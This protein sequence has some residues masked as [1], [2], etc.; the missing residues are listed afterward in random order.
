MKNIRKFTACVKGIQL[1][2]MGIGKPARR[3][4]VALL[5]TCM[6][7]FPSC[8]YLDVVPDN[9]ATIDNAFNLRLQAQKYLLTC[10]S[11]LPNLG[12]M[13]SNPALV[14]GDE[15]WFFY[16]YV[17]NDP[18][19]PIPTT[20]E[21]ARGNQN[22][23][24]PMLN[25]WDGTNGGKPLFQGIR[26]CNTFLE[27]IGRVPDMES[28]EKN[29]WIAEVKFLK[30]YYHWFL[31]R[32]YGP[33]PIVDKNLPVSSSPDEVKVYRNPVDSC[34]NYIVDLIDSAALD[35][36]AV[37]DFPVSEMGRI[38]KPIAL[39]IKA[40]ILMNYASPLFNGNSDYANFVDNKG[41]QL[42]NPAYDPSKWQRAAQACKEAIDLCESL[43]YQL[44]HF[45]PPVGSS[46]VSIGPEIQTQMDIRN[47]V[48]EKWNSEMIWG[49]SNSM[50]TTIQQ[51]GL[52]N[53]DPL[54]GNQ[55]T[56]PE[57]E[58]APP[59][60][61][62]RLFYTKNG[63][64]INQ[65][66]T[67]NYAAMNSLNTAPPDQVYLQPGYVTA[68]LN[69][70]REPRFYA[71]LGFDGGT[72]YGHGRYDDKSPWHIEGRA[73]GYSGKA[74]A[75]GYSITGY[76]AKKMVHYLT[77]MDND[78][79]LVYQPYPWPIVRL[80]DLY[81]YY[82]EA[83]NE[84]DD[85]A[86]EALKWINL[87]RARAGIPSVQESWDNFSTNPGAYSTKEGFR[88]IIH[89]ERLIEMAFE[90]NRFWDLRRWKEA[91]PQMNSPVEGWDITKADPESYY[92][93]VLLF[94][95]TYPSKYY[96]WPISEHNIV[97]N[98]NLLQNPGW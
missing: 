38:T 90:G 10:Y 93:P 95:Q 41:R 44:Y 97:T 46:G 84:S 96:F 53:I 48:C 74:R 86:G 87:V 75:Q 51:Y 3:I 14:T 61:I 79:R 85:H 37:V 5:L 2:R 71:D 12:D 15:I 11:Y 82:S 56:G 92:T 91:L 81:L 58:Y 8:D 6:I 60:K 21:M 33:I 13:K 30:A 54:R 98:S 64:P 32:M 65:D 49:A 88:K 78:G 40:R 76:Y 28:S 24:D 69:F 83:L 22:I 16:P 63:L 59:L 42:F 39:A 68:H 94:A 89:Q 29:R 80:A 34:F 31:L 77:I 66:K 9:V 50:V 36:P 23:N 62:A 27:N 55:N 43:G 52:A 57:G 47:A 35:L 19:G 26:D 73:G 4:V 18:W 25:Y 20:W 45:I 1:C 17:A 67:W 7:A 70:D 72:W